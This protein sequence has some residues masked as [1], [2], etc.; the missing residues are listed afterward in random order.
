[1]AQSDV[2]VING[3]RVVFIRYEDGMDPSRPCSGG[4]DGEC[5]FFTTACPETDAGN[6]ACAGGAF[7]P[8][9][10]EAAWPMPASNHAGSNEAPAVTAG[11]TGRKDDAGKL[12]IT[13]LFDDMPHALEAVTE[14][15]QWAITKKQPVPYARG[16]WQG[17]EPFQPRYRAAQLRHMLNAAKAALAGGA[18]SHLARDHETGLLELAHI[19][20]DAMFQL[21]MAVR[22]IKDNE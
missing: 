12:D 8:A 11:A 14:V 16:S 9:P 15:L 13:L 19:A 7:R 22:E 4:E 1:M 18:P 21:E 10:A 2:Q 5:P 20:T 6:L 3:K 17:V